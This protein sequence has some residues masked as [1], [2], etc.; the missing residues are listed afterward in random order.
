MLVPAYHYKK[1]LGV[2]HVFFFLF[3]WDWG[4][5][6][7]LCSCKAGSLPLEYCLQSILLWLLWRWGLENYLLGWP[8]TMILLISASQIARITGVSHWW[9]T[10]CYK[11]IHVIHGPFHNILFY[12]LENYVTD[13]SN[14]QFYSEANFWVL[15]MLFFC[16]CVCMSVSV[17]GTPWTTGTESSL[18]F[19]SP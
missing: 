5:K 13:Y 12:T 8:Q 2:W 18:C 7:G 1:P 6:S 3:W 9:Y 10:I 19:H 14:F 15:H 16:V 4:L 11:W 17:T